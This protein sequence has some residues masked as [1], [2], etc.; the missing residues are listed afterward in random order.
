MKIKGIL[1]GVA[2]AS[3]LGIGTP[4]SKFIKCGTMKKTGA[5]SNIGIYHRPSPKCKH[6]LRRFFVF[7]EPSLFKVRMTDATEGVMEPAKKMH[8]EMDC[9]TKDVF[10]STKAGIHTA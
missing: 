8:I 9:G 2:S 10:N 1:I 5:I 7:W 6:L 4:F 3:I